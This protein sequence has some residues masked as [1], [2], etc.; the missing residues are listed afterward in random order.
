MFTYCAHQEFSVNTVEEGLDIKIKHPIRP[1][2]PLARRSD[3][4]ER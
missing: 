2:A 3:R 1:P 4:I